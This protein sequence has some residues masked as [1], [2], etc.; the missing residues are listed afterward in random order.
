MSP[1]AELFDERQIDPTLDA[2]IRRGLCTCFPPDVAVFSHTRAWNGV[3]PIFTALIRDRDEVVAHAAVIDRTLRVG[4]RPL[5]VAGVGNVFV[6]PAERGRGL[7]GEVMT[8]AM[9][10][11]ARRK[12]DAGLLFCLPELATV[13]ARVGWQPVDRPVRRI[14]DGCDVPIPAKNVTMFYP[15]GVVELPPGP[16]HLAGDDW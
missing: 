14:H 4:Q 5:R 13:Y 10:E 16:I 15:L 7:A 2:A 12:F 9:A 1:S 8:Q 3:V 6:L 11:A